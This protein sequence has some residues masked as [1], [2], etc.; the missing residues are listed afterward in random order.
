MGESHRQN[1]PSPKKCTPYEFIYI[2]CSKQ[3]K[4]T[5]GFR[6][7]HVLSLGEEVGT[8]KERAERGSW[9]SGNVPVLLG[10]GDE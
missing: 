10:G 8:W 5:Y 1:K 9:H 7:R 6:G 4:L 3:A 2:N